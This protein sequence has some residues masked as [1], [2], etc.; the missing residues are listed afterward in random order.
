MLFYLIICKFCYCNN[1][2]QIICPIFDRL[3][4][5]NLWPAWL[6]AK[7]FFIWTSECCRDVYSPPTSKRHERMV[8]RTRSVILPQFSVVF[9]VFSWKSTGEVAGWRA[10]C[11]RIARTAPD[12]NA[13]SCTVGSLATSGAPRLRLWYIVSSPCSQYVA[14]HVVR[15][16]LTLSCP[17]S[18]C[19][20]SSFVIC[21]RIHVVIKR[22]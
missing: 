1:F 20:F 21:K 4:F 12:I 13:Q 9:V 16:D 11:K 5:I 6:P 10:K 14:E 22:S 17:Q 18:R 2:Y 15:M 19:A 3:I 7:Y 8:V